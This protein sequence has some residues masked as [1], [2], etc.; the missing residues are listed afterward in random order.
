NRVDRHRD[1]LDRG[2]GGGRTLGGMRLHGQ[3]D[4]AGVVIGG[5]ERQAGK[6]RRRQRQRAAAA[7]E[8]VDAVGER[9]AGRQ[10]VDGDGVGGVEIGLKLR[11]DGDPDRAVLVDAR[12]NRDRVRRRQHRLVGNRVDRHR[13]GLD[14][15]VGGRPLL[16]ALPIYGQRDRAGVVIGGVERQAGKLRRRQRQRAAV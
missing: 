9:G 11:G 15:G 1:G 14:R 13:D 12:R 16:G 2:V 3:R 6:L 10:A 7:K 4:R 5:V 8:R